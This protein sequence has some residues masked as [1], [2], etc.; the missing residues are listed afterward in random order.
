MSKKL[1]KLK[2]KKL[3]KIKELFGDQQ[4]NR[5]TDVQHTELVALFV[6]YLAEPNFNYHTNSKNE[7]QH[8]TPNIDD[9]SK[10]GPTHVSSEKSE[11]G[12]ELVT[13]AERS[14]VTRPTNWTRLHKLPATSEAIFTKRESSTAGT[15][16]LN[17]SDTTKC[18]PTNWTRLHKLPAIIEAISSNSSTAGSDYLNKQGDS[19]TSKCQLFFIHICNEC[20]RY[21]PRFKFSFYCDSA[22]L[23]ILR[24]F[25]LNPLASLLTV[26]LS[27]L[28]MM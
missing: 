9:D 7:L 13:I 14:S 23:Q 27:F 5:N 4:E 20:V 21:S 17:N 24:G 25:V 10:A 19:I 1:K 28:L 8:V 6:N 15:D 12:E 11:K 16:Y 3:N 2:K 26:Q 18:R 22:P